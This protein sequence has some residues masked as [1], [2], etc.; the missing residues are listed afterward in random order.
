MEPSK[1][2]LSDGFKL[3]ARVEALR[4]DQ[5]G[6]LT[7]L[8]G[9][10]VFLVTIFGVLAF[11]TNMA[12]YNRIVAQNAVD[13]AADSAALWEARGC[14]MLQN[15]NNLHYTIDLGLGIAE[16]AAAAACIVSAA[17]L[18]A[19]L[20]A[21]AFFGAGEATIRPARMITCTVC[22]T[23]PFIDLAQQLFYAM[24]MPVEQAIVD[25]TPY[26]AF[27]NANACARGS[28]ADTV[29]DAIGGALS[30]VLSSIG[31][32]MPG[33]SGISSAISSVLGAIPIY[34]VPLDPND[35]GLLDPEDKG[36][37]VKKKDNNGWP[38]DQPEWVGIAGDVGGY[39]GCEDLGAPPPLEEAEEDAKSLDW[40]G[41]YGWDDQYFFGWPGFSTWIA[42]KKQ[43]DELLGLG[44]LVWLNGGM[45]NSDYLQNADQVSKTMWTG[46]VTGKGN[47]QIPG[48]VAIASSQIQG[49]P[50]ICHGAADAKGTLIKVYL[51]GSSPTS[52]E[53]Y[54]IYH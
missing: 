16:D 37:Y 14:N 30:T 13:S 31:V 32:S 19:E 34:A 43:Q 40:D 44:N 53:D 36:L 2:N 46:S 50:V 29:G 39:I 26:I 38:L 47:L 45:K 22:D 15:L 23:M 41:T 7:L 10:M 27:A 35:F 8:A 17:L 6:S 54:F 25:A 48:Y 49:T 24:I 42:G 3:L 51:P 5:R 18:A 12:I 11:D 52:V 33:V 1:F 4:S 21:D 20:V 9:M 28:G